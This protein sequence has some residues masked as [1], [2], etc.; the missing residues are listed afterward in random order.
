MNL[1]ISR[2]AHCKRNFATPLISFIAC[3][4]LL[5]LPAAGCHRLT[6]QQAEGK[7]LYEV[8]CAHCH[9]DNDLGLQKVPPD[10]HAVFGRATLPSGAP[11]TDAQVAHVV[12]QGKGLMPSFAGRFTD[13]Q[14]S[15]LLAYLHTGLR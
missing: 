9:R 7:H 14:M 13:E 12:Q 6:P 11:A 2:C 15:A 4:G 5:I 10:L 8:R 3:A 1:L